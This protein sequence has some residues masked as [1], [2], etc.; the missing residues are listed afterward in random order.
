MEKF[1]KNAVWDC[2]LKNTHGE[3]EVAYDQD[4][5]RM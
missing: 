2:V 5:T 1:E 4:R 3:E